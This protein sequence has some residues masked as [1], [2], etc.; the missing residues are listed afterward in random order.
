MKILLFGATGRTGKLILKKALED[1]HKVTAIVRDKTRV[2]E[3]GADLVQG[4]PYDKETVLTT[5]KGCD[6]VIST[7]NVSRTT[8]N[9]WAKLRSPKDFMSRSIQNA[10]EGMKENNVKRIVVLSTLGAGDSKDKMPKLFNLFISMTNIKYAFKDHTRQEEILA[11]S[12]SD[13][14]VI[15][16]PMLT[17]DE[18][19]NEI[20]VNMG[21]GTRLNKNINR[22]TVARFILNILNEDKYFRKNIAISNK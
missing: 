12:D 18:G 1:G 9:P 16:L 10:L 19:E 2:Q 11:Q 17:S 14:T 6:A 4:T 5:I 22:E 13:W 7:L 8:D 20:I 21:D 3:P 15:R